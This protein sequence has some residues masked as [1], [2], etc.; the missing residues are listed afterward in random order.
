[1]CM[2][3]SIAVNSRLIRSQSWTM[4]FLFALPTATLSFCHTCTTDVSTTDV[5]SHSAEG[6][7]TGIEPTPRAM[8]QAP[9]CP[10]PRGLQHMDGR[11]QQADEHPCH[12][13]ELPENRVHIPFPWRTL[14]VHWGCLIYTISVTR[15]SKERQPRSH[16]LYPEHAPSGPHMRVFV[17]LR[18]MYSCTLVLQC[19]SSSCTRSFELIPLCC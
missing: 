1:M 6:S 16:P 18:Q 10:P 11:H 9:A 4:C 8:P 5:S 19:T 13:R 15:A 17:S 12:M 7:H 2:Q 14:I 3:S